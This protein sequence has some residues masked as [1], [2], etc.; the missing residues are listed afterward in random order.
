MRVR[1]L[2]TA[3][4]VVVL[5]LLVVAAGVPAAAQQAAAAR[6]TAET[7]D[8][9]R[10]APEGGADR[11]PGEAHLDRFSGPQGHLRHLPVLG[12]NH[13]AEPWPGRGDRLGSHGDRFYVDTPPDRGGWFYAVLI[14]D[15]IGTLYPVLVPFR[16]K[17]FA[18]VSPQTS[19]PEEQLAARVT[20]IKAAPTADR[21][22][23]RGLLLRVQSRAG[24]ARSSGVRFRSRNPRIC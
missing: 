10:L 19:A 7:V 16:N 20:G 17:T 8:D 18:P 5:S 21:G 13:L 23:H 4:R 24:P 22:H 3:G 1:R 9:V 14:R 6:D 12:G 11:L 15:T 2:T